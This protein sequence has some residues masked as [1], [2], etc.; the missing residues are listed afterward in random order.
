MA[1]TI[2]IVGNPNAGKSSIFNNLTGLTQKVGNYPGV[3]VD[4][5]IGQLKLE[6][7]N[8]RVVDLPGMYSVYAKS[9]DEAVCMRLLTD[10]ADPDYPDMLIVVIDAT[11]LSRNLLFFSQIRDLGFSCV[12]ALT[13]VDLAKRNGIDINIRELQ[14]QLGVSIVPLNPR[15]GSGTKSLIAALAATQQEY[16]PV[17]PDTEDYTLGIKLSE[18]YG[19]GTAYSALVYACNTDLHSQFLD[20]SQQSDFDQEILESGFRKQ[21]F[22]AEDTYRRYG[23]I[24]EK[25]S[26]AV[27]KKSEAEKELQTD[28]MDQVLLHK[29]WGNLI[30]FLTLFVVFQTIYKV[31]EFPMNL[32]DDLFLTS[33]TFMRNLLPSGWL[34][35]LWIDG[36]WSGLGGIVIFIPQIALL[37]ALV[38]ILED[39]GYMARISFL[40][41]RMLRKVGL[42]GY[43]TMPLISSYA[44]AVP[45]IMATRTIPN[46]TER[47]LAILTIP[48]LS[49]S[50][51]LPVYVIMIGLVIPDEYVWGFIHLQ[52][53]VLFMVYIVGTFFSLLSAYVMSKFYK[54]KEKSHFFLELPYYR[55]P[56]WKNVVMSAYQKTRIFV[57]DAG[58][59]IL[60]IS[61]I[62]WLLA[63]YAPGSRMRDIEQK[64]TE[65]YGTVIDDLAPEVKNTMAAEKLAASYAGIL[66]QTIE[67][68]IRPLGFD[69]KIGIAL[70]TSFAAREVFVSTMSTIYALGDDAPDS[71]LISKM[72]SAKNDQGQV[73]FTLGTSLALL[74]FYML[75]MQCMSTLAIIRRETQSWRFPVFV[76]IYLTALAYF[77][78]LLTQW[79]F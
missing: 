25:M 28:R 42:S 53:L 44:C 3:T 31:A 46:K 38:N 54:A 59:I 50:A 23:V 52:G 48:M 16:I 21:K 5:K 17:F 26:S 9:E 1:K 73:V 78:A 29:V 35:D 62:L 18:K 7:E 2:G 19:F 76:F 56:R 55:A 41:D 60:L 49:C 15:K 71:T 12:I 43:S 27:F 13:M 51:R 65:Q 79:I 67:P 72:K 47:L 10:A 45:S 58:K 20:A 75:A 4:R 61:V 63:S 39:S 11:H 34:S 30:L 57:V 37:F 66:G 70:I 40:S 69:W 14:R 24:K 68:V 8:V 32:I 33:A 6:G 77:M 22:Q 64:Y 74:V 36:I